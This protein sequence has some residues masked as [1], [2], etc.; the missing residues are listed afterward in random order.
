MWKAGSTD[1]SSTVLPRLKLALAVLLGL[2]VLVPGAAVDAD[3]AVAHRWVLY[4]GR[5][6]GVRIGFELGGHRLARSSVSIPIACSG[7][8]QPHRHFVEYFSQRHSAI[9]VDR[10]GRFHHR[11]VRLDRFE[12]EFEQISGHVRSPTIEGKI[13]LSFTQPA[14]VGNEECHSGKHPH[15]PMEALSFRAYR[16]RRGS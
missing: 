14:R 11:E 13:A 7:G 8:N 15:G 1:A 5:E 3:G 4:S 12:Y 2:A 16:H 9:R 10:Q 6:S